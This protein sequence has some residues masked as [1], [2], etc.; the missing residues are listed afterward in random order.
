MGIIKEP[1]EAWVLGAFGTTSLRLFFRWMSSDDLGD[2]SRHNGTR[3][4]VRI[5]LAGE[6]TKNLVLFGRINSKY[7]HE[8][9]KDE[10]NVAPLFCKTGPISMLEE[11]SIKPSPFL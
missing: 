6:S 2:Y 11:Q 9:T 4:N 1:S 8:I 7:R 10:S 5:V 3:A